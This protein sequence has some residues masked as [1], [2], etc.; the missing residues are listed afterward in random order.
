MI[1]KLIVCSVIGVAT[2]TGCHQQQNGAADSAATSSFK[3]YKLRGKV[4]SSDP[5]KGEVTLNHEA[6]PG[7]MEAMTMPY[8]LKDPSIVSE[9]HPGDVI[10]ADVLV[11]Q[12]RMRTFCWI[13]LWSSPKPSL[14]T[15][16]P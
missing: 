3:V 12:V 14:I 13:T 8:K 9:L 7:F 2:V 11:S 5:A 16:L 15:G 1:R 6:I 10:T 4:V